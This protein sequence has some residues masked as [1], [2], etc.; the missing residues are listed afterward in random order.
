MKYLYGNLP[1][2]ATYSRRTYTYLGIPGPDGRDGTIFLN[3]ARTEQRG[4]TAG[5]SPTE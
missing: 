2:T 1:K 4:H 3:V 5:T